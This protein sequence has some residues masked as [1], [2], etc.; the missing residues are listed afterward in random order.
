MWFYRWRLFQTHN[1]FTRKYHNFFI[2]T[3]PL[4]LLI[5]KKKQNKTKPYTLGTT[6]VGILLGLQVASY[7]ISED[8]EARFSWGTPTCTVVK[9]RS[10]GQ[11]LPLSC[12][13]LR[14]HLIFPTRERPRHPQRLYKYCLSRKN[15]SWAIPPTDHSETGFALPKWRIIWLAMHMVSG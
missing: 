11:S 10:N 2:R 15:Y 12:P 13:C 14:A 9:S 6:K 8:K 3:H 5:E 7:I 1:R 4:C